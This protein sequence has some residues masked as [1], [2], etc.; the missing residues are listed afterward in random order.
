MN[1]EHILHEIQRTAKAN[2]GVPLG[3]TRFSQETGIKSSDWFGIYWA[4][5]GDAVQDAGFSPNKLQGAIDEEILLNQYIELIREVGHL[6][7]KG[8]L[9]LKRR[10]NPTFLN[11]KTFYARFGG[12]KVGLIKRLTLYCENRGNC[13]DILRLCKEYEPQGDETVQVP[14]EATG[15][16]GFVYLMKSGR[17]YKIGRTNATGRR[18]YELAIQLPEKATTVHII[19]TDDPV[20]IEAY[21]HKR[22]ENVR[23]NGEWFELTSEQVLAFKRRKFM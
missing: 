11:E 15:N 9:R 23:K 22:F 2:G 21:W 1:K 13:E 14:N 19:K 10:R 4:R 8:E 18:E 6:P 3:E 12:S 17:H 20:G 16:I 7:V 5:W